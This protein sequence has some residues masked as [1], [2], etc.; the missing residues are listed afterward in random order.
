MTQIFGFEKQRDSVTIILTI[1]V[2]NWHNDWNKY[3]YME[4]FSK[5]FSQLINNLFFGYCKWN[6]YTIKEIL[7]NKTKI[8]L[9]QE[10]D[11]FQIFFYSWKCTNILKRNSWYGRFHNI[12]S[13]YLF[14]IF[15]C[16]DLPRVSLASMTLN[17]NLIGHWK[18]TKPYYILL[19]KRWLID[20]WKT[21][22]F[23]FFYLLFTCW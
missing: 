6:Y 4:K 19:A 22:F 13:P 16:H 12:V 9:L 5:Y 11:R 14:I 8:E 15:E 17:W 7:P 10:K 21:N 18:K 1:L 23:V 2:K 20:K 3:T